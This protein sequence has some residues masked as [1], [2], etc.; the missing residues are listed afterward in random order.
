MK[1]LISIIIVSWNVKD[2]LRLCLR[3]IFL[4]YNLDTVEV[5]VVDNA[6]SDGSVS[7]VEQEFPHVRV[8]A[9]EINT[10][11]ASANNIGAR[12]ATG[13]YLLLLNPDTEFFDD[14]VL[15]VVSL[16]DHNPRIAMVGPRLLNAD[17]TVQPSVRRFPRVSDQLAIALKLH[18][19]F[20]SMRC[21]DRYFSRDMDYQKQQDVEQ[22]MG[23]CM[24][25]KRPVWEEMHGFDAGYFIWFEEVDLCRR[26]VSAGY[27]IIYSPVCSIIH[28]G[29]QSF[30]QVL[31]YKKQQWFL[32]S[33]SRYMKKFFPWGAVCIHAVLSPLSLI[34]AWVVQYA[35]KRS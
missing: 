5:I 21:L 6:S 32:A 17:K 10:G 14:S 16:F 12:V 26:I 8:L 28:H 35:K 24:C 22:I 33:Q 2:L 18:H 34:E 29:G 1:P 19:I 13:E 7:M 20:P 27:R 11:F 23:A 4:Y 30:Q 9:Q 31:G 25:I 3:S 15:S